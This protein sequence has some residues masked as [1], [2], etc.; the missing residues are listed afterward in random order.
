MNNI[1]T[2]NEV[3]Q[4]LKN[5]KL[6]DMKPQDIFDRYI[7]YG[8][9]EELNTPEIQQLLIQHNYTRELLEMLDFITDK[10]VIADILKSNLLNN[11]NIISMQGQAEMWVIEH[12]Q[13]PKERMLSFRIISNNADKRTL[14]KGPTIFSQKDYN[15]YRNQFFK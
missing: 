14:I 7:A 5:K 12:L 15:Q 9:E 4:R 6:K 11:G 1:V 10:R 2:Y 3:M 13:E 8:T